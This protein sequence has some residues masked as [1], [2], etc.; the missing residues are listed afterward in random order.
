MPRQGPFP[1]LDIVNVDTMRTTPVPSAIQSE[2][3]SLLVSGQASTMAEAERLFL[4]AHL[5]EIADLAQARARQV[6]S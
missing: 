4:D 2:I 5:R 6:P 1:S 3:D